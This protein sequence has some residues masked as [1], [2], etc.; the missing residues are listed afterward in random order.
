MT[1]PG[2]PDARAS[3]LGTGVSEYL[4]APRQHGERQK[5]A[6]KIHAKPK[7]LHPVLV[8]LSQTISSVAYQSART[9]KLSGPVALADFMLLNLLHG[10]HQN[11]TWKLIFELLSSFA[12]RGVA[13][14]R[15]S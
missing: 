14:K 1:H 4:R 15:C 13:S 3:K 5:E 8:S 2:A 7:R 12:S 10:I 6:A 9:C 11:T